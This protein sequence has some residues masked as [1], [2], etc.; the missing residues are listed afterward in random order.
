[1]RM[2]EAALQNIKDLKTQIFGG[3]NKFVE[4]GPNIQVLEVKPAQHFCFDESVEID[5]VADHTG[6]RI[7]LSAYRYFEGVVVAVAIR[8]VALPV[9]CEVL[10]R[11]HT[12]TVKPV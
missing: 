7:D 4:F 12:F 5:Q 6:G 3:R 9:H 2:T 1:M 11:R 8:V 10:L